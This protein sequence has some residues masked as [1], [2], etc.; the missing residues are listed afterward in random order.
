[1]G[2]I[3][4]GS[5]NL[6]SGTWAPIVNLEQAGISS[7][8]FYLAYYTL[9]NNIVTC[10]VYGNAQ[11]IFNFIQLSGVLGISIPIP[12]TNLNYIGIGQISGN[13]T[14]LNIAT[15]QFSSLFVTFIFETTTITTFNSN[16]CL[17]FQYEIN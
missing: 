4:K 5:G 9:V 8:T 6:E 13:A 17:S 10:T 2:Y 11:F 16:F 14:Q 12:T 7:T 15:T 1:M 3:I